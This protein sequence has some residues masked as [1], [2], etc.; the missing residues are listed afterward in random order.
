MVQKNRREPRTR[1]HDPRR[2]WL[3]PSRPVAICL[4]G[5]RP[6]GRGPGDGTGCC[7]RCES[8]ALPSPFV[9]DNSG[10]GDDQ[11]HGSGPANAPKE[12]A[13]EAV[14]PSTTTSARSSARIIGLRVTDTRMSRS[15][16]DAIS[17]R[18]LWEH[19]PRRPLSSLFSFSG[20]SLPGLNS[21]S[22][23]WPSSD[24]PALRAASGWSAR[25]CGHARRG[26]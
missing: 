11:I 2:G 4:L 10:T 18:D 25:R 3:Q 23:R 26:P 5:R 7:S 1:T 14:L 19:P 13:T 12:P 24:H 8:S 15:D 16:Q 22:S 17:Q 6:A 9:G 20:S 21:A